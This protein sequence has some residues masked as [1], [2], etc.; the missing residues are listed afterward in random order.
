MDNLSL[1][2][3]ETSFCFYP[4]H[5]GRSHSETFLVD[6]SI[7]LAIYFVVAKVPWMRCIHLHSVKSCVCICN[8]L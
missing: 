5:G 8:E 2:R 3:K 6:A 4:F 7:A 1:A